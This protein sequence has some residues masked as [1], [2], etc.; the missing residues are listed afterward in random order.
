MAE[1]M[2]ADGSRPSTGCSASTA[3]R[4][5]ARGA[6][7]GRQGGR[8]VGVRGLG[9]WTLAPRRLRDGRARRGT[10]WLDCTRVQGRRRHVHRSHQRRVGRAGTWQRRSTASP[11]PTRR[12][13]RCPG[14]SRRLLDLEYSEDSSAE[15]DMNVVLTGDGRLIEGRRPP[16]RA[17]IRA[18]LTRSSRSPA[19]E[20]SR[21]PRSSRSRLMTAPRSN[22]QN[23][24]CEFVVAALLTGAI[25]MERERVNALPACHACSSGSARRSSR[26]SRHAWGDFAFGQ[27]QGMV[28]DPIRIAQIVTASASGA[29]DHP[30][31]TISAR[32]HHR[33]RPLGEV[34]A[35][36]MAAGAGYYSSPS[37]VTGIVPSGSGRCAG[38]K[39]ARSALV[40]GGRVLEVDIL[41]ERGAPARDARAALAHGSIASSSGR[42]EPP[43]VRIE[44]DLPLGPV[45]S[46]IVAG[47]L[48]AASTAVRWAE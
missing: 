6:R 48:G 13:R 11:H 44:L 35:I 39:V 29:G 45:G 37:I 10:V 7:A 21:S 20:S 22:G 26:S 12:S 4:M 5:K 32:P 31:G 41:R 38:W 2:V 40:R 30:P 1:G 27:Q 15:V 24:C 23:F 28:F 16:R 18:Q 3:E 25:R 9:R 33:R 8:T 47:F 46:E 42:G 36:G 17:R 34:A 14:S 19:G 43:R